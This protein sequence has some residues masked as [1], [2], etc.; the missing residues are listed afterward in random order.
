VWTP[1][2]HVPVQGLP[3]YVA[4]VGGAPSVMLDPLLPV[5][6]TA[7]QDGWAHVRAVNGWEGW[8]D[9][10]QLVSALPEPPATRAPVPQIPPMPVG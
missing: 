8:V 5:V 9:A 3:A 1:T 4:P 2:H 6:V 10:A 7:H